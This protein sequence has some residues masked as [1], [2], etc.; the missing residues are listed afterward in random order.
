MNWVPAWPGARF[1]LLVHHTDAEREWAYDRTSSIARLDKALDEAKA[2]GWTVVSM[3]DNWE[4]IFPL[5]PLLPDARGARG[6]RSASQNAGVEQV[7]P[8]IG[9]ARAQG[10]VR[11]LALQLAERVLSF[12]DR[13]AL[14]FHFGHEE[15]LAIVRV[16]RDQV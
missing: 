10:A 2:K 5:E 14:P 12:R 3:K 9:I 6:R 1:C 7:E 13:Y 16:R 8:D 15:P 4:T 11:P